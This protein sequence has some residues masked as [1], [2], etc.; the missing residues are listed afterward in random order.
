MVVLEILKTCSHEKVARAAVVSIG[1]DFYERVNGVAGQSGV[2]AGAYA[3]QVVRNFERAAGEG[4]RRALESAVR[5][6]DMPVLQGLRYI[7]EDALEGDRK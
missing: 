7:L 3:A 2:E 1:R 5:N 4:Q 6:A